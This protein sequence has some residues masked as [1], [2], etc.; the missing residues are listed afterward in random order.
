MQVQAF[1]TI[2]A[3]LQVGFAIVVGIKVLAAGAT[4]GRRAYAEPLAK[5]THTL[6]VIQ[7]PPIVGGADPTVCT[8]DEFAA[9]CRPTV[10]IFAPAS[11]ASAVVSELSHVRNCRGQHL[12]LG[13]DQ[14]LHPRS[15][16]GDQP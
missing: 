11:V 1:T 13:T 16:R 8:G 10:S 3:W 6:A 15:M 4:I 14:R 9:T 12:A 2:L 5:Q 7:T